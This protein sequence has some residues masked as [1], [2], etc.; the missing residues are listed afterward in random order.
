MTPEEIQQTIEGMLKVQKELQQSQIKQSEEIQQLL[1]QGR[2]QDKRIQQ[3][4]GYSISQGGD[5][6]DV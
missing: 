2:L 3:L 6:L 4:I 1:D 5:I